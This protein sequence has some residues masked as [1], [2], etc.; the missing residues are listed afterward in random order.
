ML[1]MH[2]PAA[3]AAGA[4]PADS[5]C[6]LAGIV[7]GPFGDS[8][9]PEAA[10]V[11]VAAPVTALAWVPGNTSVALAAT[12]DTVVAPILLV[13]SRHMLARTLACPD[14]THSIAHLPATRHANPPVRAAPPRG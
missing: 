9:A 10:S 2:E 7:E 5:A 4:P 6:T 12:G 13:R 11:S 8:A 14:L 3:E 1:S